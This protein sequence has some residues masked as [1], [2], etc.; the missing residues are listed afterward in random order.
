MLE[1]NAATALTALTRHLEADPG[2]DESRLRRGKLALSLGQARLAVEDLGRLLDRQPRRSDVRYHRARAR[3]RLGL[4]R[5]ALADLELL[6]VDY[7]RDYALFA[8]RAAALERLG[9]ADQA[10]ADREEVAR[11]LPG[12]A[13]ACN[14]QAW[15]SVTGPASNWNPERALPLARKAVE[16]SPKEPLFLNTLGLVQ[17]RLGQFR[18]AIATLGKS[19]KM[20]AGKIDGF[21]LLVLS[22]CHHRLG[23][24]ARARD[25]YEQALQWRQK[26]TN[27][28]AAHVEEFSAFQ[29]EAQVV[30]GRRE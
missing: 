20:G 4:A 27:L 25:C 11:L 16:L 19:L 26:Q 1:G 14:N 2:D 5:D 21:D 24:A 8:L 6:L 22:M 13:V 29:V 23:A 7:P 3:V 30:R 10:Q 17:Y 28:A 15:R 9:N 12:D 18:D